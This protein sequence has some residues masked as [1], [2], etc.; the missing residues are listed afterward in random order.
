VLFPEPDGPITA[1]SSPPLN[2]QDTLFKIVAHFSGEL[3]LTAL[4]VLQASR[5]DLVGS[6]SASAAV[7]LDD[8][9]VALCCWL[10]VDT[11]FV[12]CVGCAGCVGSVLGPPSV[13]SEAT[14]DLRLLPLL[15]SRRTRV[16]LQHLRDAAHHILSDCCTSYIS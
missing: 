1:V 10:V 5:V 15:L 14:D 9:A 2:L 7:T 16:G 11:C 3:S 12:G 6:A 8:A 13:M 4:C